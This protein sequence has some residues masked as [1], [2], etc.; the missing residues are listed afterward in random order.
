MDYGARI[1]TRRAALRLTQRELAARSGVKQ[2]LISA[3]ESGRRVASDATRTALEKAL[4]VRPSQM[5]QFLESE[6]LAA[7]QRRHGATPTVFGS[8]AK[9]TDGPESDIDLLITFPEDT[10]ITDLLALEEELTDLL[11]VPVDV[12]S[13]GSGGRVIERARVEGI[14]L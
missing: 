4:T 10:G 5:L 7:I 13:A 8:V 3:I 14:S 12:V 6:A 2:P 1:R 11:T 9:G